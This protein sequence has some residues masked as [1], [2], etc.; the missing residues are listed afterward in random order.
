MSR[1]DYAVIEVDEEA[2]Q[3][4]GQTDLSF[5]DFHTADNPNTLSR[6]TGHNN[7]SQPKSDKKLLWTI[8]FYAQFFDVDTQQVLNRC[9]G[10]LFP[11][12]NFLDMIDGNPDL[13]GPIWVCTTVIFVLFMSSTLAA[14]LA[15]HGSDTPFNYNFQ[16]L[17]SAA[18]LMYGYTFLIPILLWGV[19]KWYGCEPGLLECLCLYGYGMLVWVPVSILSISPIE[20]FNHRTIANIIRWTSVGVGAAMSTTFLVRNLYPVISRAEGKTSRLMLISIVAAHLGMAL[21]VKLT[22]FA[23]STV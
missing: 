14:W 5:Q 18:A 21:A 1:K 19:M 23:Y 22:F 7:T 11:R 16:T 20:L 6:S 17:L 13:Y 12:T 2:P 3:L 4:G 15:W 9:W 8:E 10:S